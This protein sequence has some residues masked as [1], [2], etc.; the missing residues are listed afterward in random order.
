M[1]HRISLIILA[2]AALAA[3]AHAGEPLRLADT[4]FALKPPPGDTIEYHGAL[5]LDG[6]AGSAGRFSGS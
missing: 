6:A 1:N 4:G 3:A 5:S 2:A